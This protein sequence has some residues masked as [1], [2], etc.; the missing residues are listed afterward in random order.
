[1]STFEEIAKQ[2]RDYIG[3][4]RAIGFPVNGL[5]WLAEIAE[6]LAEREKAADGLTDAKLVRE[7]CL[8]AAAEKEMH[9]LQDQLFAFQVRMP[10]PD[11]IVALQTDRDDWRRRAE[12][13]EAKLREYTHGPFPDLHSWEARLD[14]CRGRAEKAEAELTA[15]KEGMEHDAMIPWSGGGVLKYQEEL[16][17]RIRE[18]SE[19]VVAHCARAN[20]AEAALNLATTE[21]D[22]WRRRA[23]KLAGDWQDECLRSEALEFDRDRLLQQLRQDHGIVG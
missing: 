1:M 16:R 18:Y 2:V 19:A 3:R 4:Q 12:A 14:E 13:A 22:A 8:R 6:L 7:Q 23:Q 9:N 10:H 11:G 5:S 17:A 21:R 20:K 15:I